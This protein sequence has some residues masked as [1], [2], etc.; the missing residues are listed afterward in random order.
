MSMM[1][2]NIDR[3]ILHEV[4][5][6]GYEKKYKCPYCELRL[7]RSKLPIH[8]Q[9]KHEDLIP[10]GYTALR[11]AFNTIN[12][13]DH[14]SCVIC[15]KETAW[16]E[17]KARYERLC[18]RKECEN[19]YKK[20]VAERNKKKYG[21]DRPQSDPIYNEEIQK[22]ALAGRG[23]SGN[24]K[25]RDGGVIEFTGSYEKKFL[26]F[27]DKIMYCNSEDI[28]A[29][30]P[31]IPYKMPDG[32]DH[33]YIPDFLYIPYNLIIEIKDGGDN[34]NKNQQY[35]DIKRVKMKAK[36]DA[37]RLQGKYNYLR[38][39]N[40]DFSQLMQ[41]MAILKYR[42]ID[43]QS[44]DPIMRMNENSLLESVLSENP[45]GAAVVGSAPQP[46]VNVDPA[47]VPYESNPDNY[48]MVQHMKNNVFNYSITKDPIQYK[49]YSIDPEKGY[50]VFET[51]KG[52]FDKRYTTFKI[53]DKKKAKELYEQLKEMSINGECVN[54]KDYIYESLTGNMILTDDQIKY[55]NRF[56][57]VLNFYDN[58]KEQCDSL[59]NYL[60]CN[61]TNIDIMEEQCREL[62]NIIY[63]L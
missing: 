56:E 11:V 10:E 28:L 22:K 54:S 61:D 4:A 58:I 51:D 45:I 25:F 14:G 23:I 1:S 36:E 38:L 18:G 44:N 41:M 48:Y 13:K 39:T 5:A 53:K 55:D 9:D 29:P 43:D 50:K 30:A 26:E 8:I 40:N 49:V 57:E 20:I 34:P 15:R 60:K 46:L 37:V 12:K 31:S 27:M 6:S 42:L 63:N 24:Y 62:E 35:N 33:I 47:P 52:K 3:T 17:Q 59:Y 16:N 32:S 21:V 7:I 2:Y 19:E